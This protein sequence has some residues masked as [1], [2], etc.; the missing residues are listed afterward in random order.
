M[1][2]RYQ[3]GQDV[4]QPGDG[5]EFPTRMDLWNHENGPYVPGLDQQMLPLTQRDPRFHT[6]SGKWPASTVNYSLD[7]DLLEN[8]EQGQAMTQSG[9]GHAPGSFHPCSTGYHAAAGNNAGVYIPQGPQLS[10]YDS[11]RFVEDDL[12]VD[13]THSSGL[14]N[15][16]CATS[17][18][19]TGNTFRTVDRSLSLGTLVMEYDPSSARACGCQ[20]LTSP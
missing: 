1:E 10:G 6:A 17:H 9:S 14:G 7:M 20:S 19:R 18:S 8:A 11:L 13:T 3:H 16:I 2:Y 12:F 15:G 4:P 5:D